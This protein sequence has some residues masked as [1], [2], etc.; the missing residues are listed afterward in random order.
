V[1]SFPGHMTHL[2]FYSLQPDTRLQ[3]EATYTGRH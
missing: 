3:C 2:R 1:K